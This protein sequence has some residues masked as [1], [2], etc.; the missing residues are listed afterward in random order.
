[1]GGVRA[2]GALSGSCLPAGI[3]CPVLL[4]VRCCSR[5][6]SC[7]ALPWPGMVPRALTTPAD[8]VAAWPGSGRAC[9]G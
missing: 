7:A 9:G 8:T 3:A 5:A 1:M 4:L 6:A 2:Q